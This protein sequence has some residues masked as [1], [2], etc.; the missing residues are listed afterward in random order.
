MLSLFVVVMS[1]HMLWATA[2][3]TVKVVHKIGSHLFITLICCKQWLADFNQSCII[4]VI[5][6]I[7]SVG[8]F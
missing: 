7:M 2:R 5:H 1:L 6:N 4:T 3:V 8:L